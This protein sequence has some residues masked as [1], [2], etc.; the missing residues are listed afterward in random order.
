M[1]STD[2]DEIRAEL[3]AVLDR[4][5]LDMV[6]ANGRDLIEREYSFE[7]ATRR[8]REVLAAVARR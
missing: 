3:L 4:P 1:D 2:P 6:S 5:D 8:Y 7:A